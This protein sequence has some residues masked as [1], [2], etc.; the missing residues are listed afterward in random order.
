[1]KP[2]LVDMSIGWGM[3]PQMNQNKIP[4]FSFNG[5]ATVNAMHLFD[6]INIFNIDSYIGWE[7]FITILYN[8]PVYLMIKEYYKTHPLAGRKENLFI[9][10][11]TAVLN[12]FC[13]NMAKEPY[14]MLFFLLMYY[15][16]MLRHIT[17]RTKCILIIGVLLLCTILARKYY[18]LIIMFFIFLVF[19]VR[20]L[21]KKNAKKKL[22]NTQ[23]AIYIILMMLAIS[24]FHYIFMITM[25][26]KSPD[27]YEELIRVNNRLALGASEITPVFNANGGPLFTAE[28]LLKILRLLFPIE[29]LLKGK[30]TYLFLLANQFLL[31]LFMVKAFKGMERQKKNLGK[32]Q[33]RHAS[34]RE[35]ALFTYIAFLLCS[36][37][38]EPD[39]GSWIRHQG[40]TFPIMILIL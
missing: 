4:H 27:I 35:L 25:G 10:M 2:Q 9:Y 1:M 14:Q 39:F 17:Y 12:I 3:I 19:T 37:A 23:L 30:I 13:F 8:I 15:C 18:G 38:F 32:I 29:L 40:V 22:T 21:F 26:G 7:I 28:Y 20:Y 36:A 24:G 33:M 31:V 16:I 5:N 34:T 6:F 11:N